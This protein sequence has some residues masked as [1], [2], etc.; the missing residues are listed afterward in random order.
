MAKKIY[1]TEAQ[2][3]DAIS[4]VIKEDFL[5]I[6][7]DN[8]YDI[9]RFNGDDDEEETRN[10]YYILLYYYGIEKGFVDDYDGMDAGHDTF[11]T[12]EEALKN[13]KRC[14]NYPS[15][16]SLRDMRED[17]MVPLYMIYCMDDE[18][19]NYADNNAPA[20]GKMYISKNDKEYF[21]AIKAL[22]AKDSFCSQFE[23]TLI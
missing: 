15:N 7:T 16:S 22:I 12:Y 10:Y 3:R 5:A 14:C 20:D 1:I 18:N 2:L 23:L 13:V 6:P 21:N 19:I 17:G 9:Q 8:G 4:R 11:D